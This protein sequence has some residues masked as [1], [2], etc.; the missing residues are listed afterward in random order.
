MQVNQFVLP[1]GD[2]YSGEMNDDGN[3]HGEDKIAA[4]RQL[5]AEYF[6][7]EHK[8]VT[9]HQLRNGLKYTGLVKNGVPNG[10]GYIQAAN[11]QR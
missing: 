1:N 9:N 5:W 8:K 11:G 4:H 3:P 7:T 2:I 10:L 6:C